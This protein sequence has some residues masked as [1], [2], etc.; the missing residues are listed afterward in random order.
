MCADRLF[1]HW[2]FLR[3][4][5][6]INGK[7][8]GRSG[9][10]IFAHSSHRNRGNPPTYYGW[11]TRPNLLMVWSMGSRNPPLSKYVMLLCQILGA[12]G[13]PG[14]SLRTL[15]LNLVGGGR[16]SRPHYRELCHSYYILGSSC[17]MAPSSGFGLVHGIQRV[18]YCGEWKGVLLVQ[19]APLFPS[20]PRTVPL[21]TCCP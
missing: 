8:S 16:V 4:S 20:W 18:I 11:F 19:S 7:V 17:A 14:R 6:S 9:T 12:I 21:F 10:S 3:L 5:L 2:Y 15:Y 13:R 1:P